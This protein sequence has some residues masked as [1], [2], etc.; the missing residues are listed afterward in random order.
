MFGSRLCC[1]TFPLSH[2]ARLKIYTNTS[3]ISAAV[4]LSGLALIFLIASAKDGEL[5][6]PLYVGQYGPKTILLKN[7]MNL[8]L[9]ER[10]DP[11]LVFCT[12]EKFI[13]EICSLSI[14]KK[15][16]SVRGNNI[17]LRSFQTYGSKLYKLTN[18]WKMPGR[19]EIMTSVWSTSLVGNF[20]CFKIK[21]NT[22][23]TI[24]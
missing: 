11:V 2:I 7:A 3:A 19:S 1:V 22:I 15:P 14:E 9:A 5:R 10:P 21:L 23:L 20:Y 12:L 6:K 17:H 4:Q 16:Y 13:R 8:E 24:Q 18:A